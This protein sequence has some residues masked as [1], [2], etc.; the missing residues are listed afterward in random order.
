[1]RWQIL[2][3][4][5]EVNANALRMH[6]VLEVLVAVLVSA[7]ADVHDQSTAGSGAEEPAAAHQWGLAGFGV[8]VSVR[9]SRLTRT[10]NP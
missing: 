4:F 1:V 8:C 5:V 6:T 10:L 7:A 9:D 3:D 2:V